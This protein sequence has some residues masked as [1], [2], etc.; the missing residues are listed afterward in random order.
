MKLLTLIRHAKSDHDNDLS[1]FD[2]P[3][4]ER[5]KI[6][7]PKIGEYIAKNLPMP[8]LI[9]SSPSVRTATTAEIIADK[10]KYPVEKIH[11]ID[12]LYLCSVPEYIEILLR[13]NHKNRHICIISHNP[14]TTALAN[15]LTDEDIDNI[16]TCGVAHIELDLFKWDDI[17]PGIGKLKQFIVP[18]EI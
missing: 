5:G 13:Q 16:P 6:D 3:I 8:D 17:E 12:E 4:S 15:M 9:I 18:K 14:G 11:Y 7:A 10:L 2:R 1:D